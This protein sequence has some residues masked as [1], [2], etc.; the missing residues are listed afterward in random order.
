MSNKSWTDESDH[1]T[2]T[3][4]RA[5]SHGAPSPTHVS[6]SRPRRQNP[7]L[8]SAQETHQNIA[9]HHRNSMQNHSWGLCRQP[10]LAFLINPNSQHKSQASPLE[11]VATQASTSH[12]GR[13]TRDPV[14]RGKRPQLPCS[15]RLRL[16]GSTSKVT[17]DLDPCEAA[18]NLT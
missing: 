5:G 14:W 2:P 4:L 8:L 3:H 1:V 10:G 11:S 16:H 7:K 15:R 17:W 13:K 18:L 9:N 6:N 12:L